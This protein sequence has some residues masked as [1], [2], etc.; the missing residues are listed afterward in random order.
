MVELAKSSLL[1]LALFIFIG[2]V[3]GFVKGKSKASI[4]AGSIS[5]AILVGTYFLSNVNTVAGFTIAFL[6]I[7]ALD[8]I[9]VKRIRK[10]KTVSPAVPMLMICILEQFTLICALI[11]MHYQA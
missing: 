3:T 7:F 2:G 11:I 1:I 5:T 6:F 4:I 8:V 10:T 9:F